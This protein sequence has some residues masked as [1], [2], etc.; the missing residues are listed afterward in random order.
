ME[1]VRLFGKEDLRVVDVEEPSCG[2]GDVIVETGAATICGTDIRIYSNGAGHIDE[3]HPVTLGHEIS[4]TVAQSGALFR[5]AYPEGTRVA[6]A[7]NYGCGVCDRCVSGNTQLCKDFRAIG[8]HED[9]G[10][11]RFVRIPEQAV[12]QGN[13]V[14]LPDN[15]SFRE[16]ALIEPMSAVYNAYER[17][18]RD[19]GESVLIMGAGPIGLMHAKLYRA[20]GAGPV[21][22]SDLLEE[23]LE[24]CRREDASFTTVQAEGVEEVVREVTEGKGVDV[25]IVAAPAPAAQEQ[26]LGLAALN[27]RVMFFGGLPGSKAEVPLN[28]NL[29]HYKQLYVTGVTRQNLRQYRQT[30]RLMANGILDLGSVFTHRYEL[31]QAPEAFENVRRGV[32][33]R[34]GFSAGE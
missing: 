12:R 23:R 29:I 33:L 30:L 2:E 32:G 8:I 31:S 16:A 13:I 28:S 9:G 26:A 4:G 10:F 27:G 6:V 3:T 18:S 22:L 14:R 20:T 5:D 24:I 25:A 1:A 21:I 17:C 34:S 19:P 11:T 7:P 15:V